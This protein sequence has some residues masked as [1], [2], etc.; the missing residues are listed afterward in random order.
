MT[1]VAL[2]SWS[3]EQQL[4][5]SVKLIIVLRRKKYVSSCVKQVFNEWIYFSIILN[6][7]DDLSVFLFILLLCVSSQSED[8]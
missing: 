8:G 7:S 1:Q 6:G 3:H 2:L 5:V 4:N